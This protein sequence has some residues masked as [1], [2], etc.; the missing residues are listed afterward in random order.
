MF[1]PH[2]GCSGILMQKKKKIK[3][4]HIHGCSIIKN[5]LILPVQILG[6][7][8]K[9]D[10]LLPPTYGIMCACILASLAKD[11]SINKFHT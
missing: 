3:I 2:Y 5:F 8:V 4:Q 7:S 10:A 9:I 1:D 11:F 6:I